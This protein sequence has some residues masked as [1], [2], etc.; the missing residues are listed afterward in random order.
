MNLNNIKYK[1]DELIEEG[2]GASALVLMLA[3]FVGIFILLSYYK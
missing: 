2:L 3:V 1:K